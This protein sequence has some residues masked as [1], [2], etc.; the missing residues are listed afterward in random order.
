M[1]KKYKP[2]AKGR[3]CYYGGPVDISIDNKKLYSCDYFLI[4]GKRRPC[5]AGPGCTVYST[6]SRAH[7]TD[8]NYLTGARKGAK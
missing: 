4:T 1:D 3:K 8:P 6:K 7:R 5:P 2:C